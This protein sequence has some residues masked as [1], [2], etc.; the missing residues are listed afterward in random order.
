MLDADVQAFTNIHETG[1]SMDKISIKTPNPK[2]RLYWCLIEFIEWRF[3]QSC[4]YFRPLLLTSAPLTF[5]LVRLPPSPPPLCVNK[6]RGM[7]LQ[8]TGCN[9]GGGIGLC[10]E[11]IQELYTLY[12][13]RFRIYKVALPPR[14]PQTDKH[15]L[16]VSG[17]FICR[18][19]RKADI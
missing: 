18:F 15:L 14:G 9:G 2:C 19:L 8:Y 6:Y 10:G 12:L 3:S 17:P 1:T 13:T 16:S 7:S 5:S 4:W 11:H